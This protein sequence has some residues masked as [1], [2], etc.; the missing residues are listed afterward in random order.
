MFI[1]FV[2]IT[3]YKFTK[4]SQYNYNYVQLYYKYNIRTFIITLIFELIIFEKTE[5]K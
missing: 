5:R 4:K 2:H 3:Y 1:V